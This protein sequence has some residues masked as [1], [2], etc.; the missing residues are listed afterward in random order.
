M[1]LH[2]VETV[3]TEHGTFVPRCPLGCDLK[4]IGSAGSR[5]TARTMVSHSFNEPCTGQCSAWFGDAT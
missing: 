5:D 1:R 3:R 2:T 4:I